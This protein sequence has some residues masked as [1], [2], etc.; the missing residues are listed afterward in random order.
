MADWEITTP[1]T[2]YETPGVIKKLRRMVP[3]SGDWQVDL[4]D[5]PQ[6]DSAGVAF[7]LWCIRQAEQRDLR[8]HIRNAPKD[9][10]SLSKAQGVWTVLQN[11][12]N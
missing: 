12:I 7:L 1:L 10:Q 4:K 3:A 2:M 5:V 6:L 9:L 8:L 11:Y